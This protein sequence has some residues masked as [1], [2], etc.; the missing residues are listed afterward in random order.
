MSTLSLSFSPSSFSL[1]LPLS[2]FLSLSLSVSHTLTLSFHVKEMQS[3]ILEGFFLSLSLYVSLFSSSPSLSFW[4]KT[5]VGGKDATGV[6]RKGHFILSSSP[7]S[8]SAMG[9][10]STEPSAQDKTC[11]HAKGIFTTAVTGAFLY[12]GKGSL[13]PRV[14]VFSTCQSCEVKKKEIIRICILFFF[15]GPA[16]RRRSNTVATKNMK[17]PHE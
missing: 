1:F 10:Q 6:S 8:I 16:G 3:S 15:I 12:L 13:F 11:A 9:S 17:K 4:R 14:R 7:G 5:E 2:L